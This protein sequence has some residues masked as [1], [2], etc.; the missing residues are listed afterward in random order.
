MEQ[1]DYS[2]A[3]RWLSDKGV[4]KSV[5]AKHFGIEEKS[6]AVTVWREKNK[7]G[8]QSFFRTNSELSQTGMDVDGLIDEFSHDLSPTAE[9][10]Y[11]GE[12][13]PKQVRE[14]EDDVERFSAS[15]WE[16]VKDRQGLRELGLLK[17][18]ASLP[19][20]YNIPLQRISA[21]LDHLLAELNLH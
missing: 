18:R 10:I 17:R 16:K 12:P 9:D 4:D 3:I 2:T 15:F 1:H 19:G 21:R 8:A 5:I 14:L 11:R 20:Q 6:I 7:L 13:T